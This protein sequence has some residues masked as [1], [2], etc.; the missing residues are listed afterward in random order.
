[1][2]KSYKEDNTVN[3]I[4][5]SAVLPDD[6]N[7][8]V[9]SESTVTDSKGNKVKIY[10]S[11]C[12]LQ[13]FDVENWNKRIY[14][15]D[16][17]MDSLDNDPMIQNDI[18]HGQWIGEWG[19]PLDTNPKRQLTMFPQTSSHRIQKYW[20]DT[21][22]LLKGTVQNLP[23][24][25]GLAMA[26]NAENNIPWSF[27]LRSLG[28]VDPVTRR[29]KR[30][31]KIITYDSVYRPSHIESYKDI[32]NE[33]AFDINVGTMNESM[34][35]EDL[36]QP[37]NES[38]NMSDIVNYVKERSA[39][40]QRMADMFKLDK[41][42]GSLNETGTRMNVRVDD[43]TTLDIPIESVIN[44]QYSDILNTAFKK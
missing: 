13:S 19:H 17:V 37:L 10:T 15:S 12:T 11:D 31:L 23:Y 34:T 39:N 40:I 16:T 6:I 20:K 25:W 36:V 5:E 28:S 29:V 4:C 41:F 9:I 22:N 30:P 8:E 21:G 26:A 7:M 27:S 42:E 1:M 35:S 38:F 33:S 3:I 2:I 43:S 18:K 32:L 44:M 24:G 14:G